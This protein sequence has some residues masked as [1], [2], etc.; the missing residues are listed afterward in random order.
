MITSDYEL[1]SDPPGYPLC[2][3]CRRNIEN[4]SAAV[5]ATVENREWQAMTPPDDRDN[6][7]HWDAHWQT[8][9]PEDRL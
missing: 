6:C 5:I 1:C 7:R 4:H 8:T 2:G 9:G 3:S